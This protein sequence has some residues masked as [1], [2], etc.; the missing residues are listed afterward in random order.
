M[1]IS[2]AHQGGGPCAGHKVDVGLLNQLWEEHGDE[3]DALNIIAVQLPGGHSVQ[4]VSGAQA[5][6]YM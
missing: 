5:R 4:E 2:H 3:D 1:A 6:L